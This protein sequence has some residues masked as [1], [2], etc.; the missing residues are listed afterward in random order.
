MGLLDRWKQSCPL[1]AAVQAE[2]HNHFVVHLVRQN[3]VLHNFFRWDNS[4]KFKKYLQNDLILYLNRNSILIIDNIRSAHAEAVK[5]LLNQAKL[6][7][8]YLLPYSPDLNPIEKLCSK[9]KALLRKFTAKSLNELPK[10]I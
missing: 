4:R 10:S 3:F 6:H 2:E 9:V 8:I 1:C 7:Y 5:A